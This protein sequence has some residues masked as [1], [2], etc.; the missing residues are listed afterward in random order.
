MPGAQEFGAELT[1][2]R[3]RVDELRAARAL[4]SQ[5]RLSLLDAA[6]F[7][8]QH[9]VDVLWPRYEELVAASRTTGGGRGDRQEQQLLRALFQRMPV[10]AVL[11]DRESVVR[12]MNFAATQLFHTRAGYATGRPL[13]ASLR[14]DG[15]AALRSQVAAVARGEGDRSLTVRLSQPSADGEVRVTLAALRPPG[16]PHPAVLAA[17]QPGVAGHPAEA[18]APGVAGHPAEAGTAPGVWY[19]ESRP[20]LAEVTR[21]AE[22]LDLV[23]DMT[24]ALLKVALDGGGPEAVLVRAAEVLHGRF[25]DWV[26]ADLAPETASGVPRRVVALGPWDAADDRTA[27]LAKQDPASCPV[28]V[29]ALSDG[30]CALRVSPPDADAFGRDATGAPVLVREEVTSLLCIPLRASATDPVRGALTLFRT[31]G[32]GAFGMAEAGV[33]DRISRHLALAMP[34]TTAPAPAAEA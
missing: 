27:S 21:H 6:L 26:I 20:D 13:A 33:A 34:R 29:D 23:D 11:L 7:E 28:V 10:A 17:F 31:G 3:R 14:R 30:V 24:T 16:E 9:M 19:P 25:A 32:R 1:D 22:L 8:L 2:F 12:R 15:Q 4:P 5:E 18:G